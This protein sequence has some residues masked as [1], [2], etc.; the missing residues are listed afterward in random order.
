M[1]YDTRYQIPGTDHVG[2]CMIYDIF[3]Y[4]IDKLAGMNSYS[5]F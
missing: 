3:N 1:S 5:R 4:G 2:V